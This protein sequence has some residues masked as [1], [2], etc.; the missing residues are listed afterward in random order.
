MSL[1]LSLSLFLVL[2]LPADSGVP[3]PSIRENT[4]YVG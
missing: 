4:K 2:R 1:S 3:P